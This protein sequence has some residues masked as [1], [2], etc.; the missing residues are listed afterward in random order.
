MTRWN[1]TCVLIKRSYEVDNEG[2]QIEYVTRREVFCNSYT[3]STQSWASAK[4]A[5]YSADDEIQLR[6]DDYEGEQDVAY[7][8]EAY[9][10]QHVMVQGD[11]TRLILKQLNQDIGDETD[12]LGP[13]TSL[14]EPVD[15][16]IDPVTGDPIGKETD[17]AN[18]S[19]L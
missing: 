2:V 4:L 18:T 8:G 10:V 9:T 5:D 16:Q 13:D 19:D 15:E 3:L 1:E 12:G 6:T 11:F 14:E 7:R 17:N